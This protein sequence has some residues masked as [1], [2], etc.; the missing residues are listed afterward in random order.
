M[1]LCRFLNRL[2]G[3]PLDLQ[4]KVMERFNLG[5]Q[6]KIRIAKLAGKLDKGIGRFTATSIRCKC[7]LQATDIG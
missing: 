7:G 1:C 4:T 6:E 2:L 5:L 3:I